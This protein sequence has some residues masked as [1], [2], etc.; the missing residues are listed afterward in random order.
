MK[1]KVKYLLSIILLLFM[2]NFVIA[3]PPVTT[4]E[5]FPQGYTIQVHPI[6]TIFKI[7]EDVNFNI[8]IFNS[9]N[10]VPIN[11]SSTCVLHLYN[12]SGNHSFIGYQSNVSNIYDYEINIMGGNF[13]SYTKSYHVFCYG[14]GIGGDYP[15]SIEVTQSGEPM[16][17]IRLVAY[18]LLLLVVVGI[19]SF[20]VSKHSGTNFESSKKSIVENHKNMGETM[21]RGLITG[22]FKNS[23]IWLYFTGWIFILILREILY[24]FGSVVIYGYFELIANIYSLGLILVTVYMIGYLISYMRSIVGILVDRDW[25]VEE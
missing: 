19:M 5:Y 8:H 3:V 25:G 2:F 9:T 10:G 15:Y 11:T 23:F 6:K 7:G 22:L 4:V 18:I 16:E 1:N 14:E 21:V 17:F 12:T 20:M 13:T 24:E